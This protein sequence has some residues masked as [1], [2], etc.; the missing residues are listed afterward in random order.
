MP[1]RIGW[2]SRTF[3]TEG[4]GRNS[5]HSSTEWTR[6]SRLRMSIRRGWVGSL[7]SR[8][9][10]RPRGAGTSNAIRGLIDRGAWRSVRD[11]DGNRPV[12]VYSARGHTTHSAV[13][14]PKPV[15]RL[16]ETTVS[17]LERRL[18]LLL[19]AELLRWHEYPLRYPQLEVLTEVDS[20]EL[21]FLV[22]G[23][24][25]GYKITLDGESLLVDSSS[26]QSGSELYRVTC[27]SIEFLGHEGYRV[28]RFRNMKPV[29]RSG[30]PCLCRVPAT[31]G[32]IWDC[33][34][35]LGNRTD[36]QGECR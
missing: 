19:D 8:R 32:A 26:R 29:D 23:R 20:G 14:E 15:R 31:V 24:S 13:L 4:A 33:W 11:A 16:G 1:L 35:G 21:W 10:T 30:R 25:G 36:R 28:A 17:T 5:S 18:H 6:T 22:P 34:A 9:Y 7:I 12:D 27:D 3:P 2:R